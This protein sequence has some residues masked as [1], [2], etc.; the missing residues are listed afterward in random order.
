MSIIMIN[1]IVEKALT[2][3]CEG[4]RS[5]QMSLIPFSNFCTDHNSSRMIKFY[6]NFYV[7]FDPLPFL[8]DSMTLFAGLVS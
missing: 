2:N 8:I 6:N 3:F 4:E 5:K 1:F 7:F